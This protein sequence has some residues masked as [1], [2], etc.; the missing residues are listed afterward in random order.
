MMD[1]VAEKFMRLGIENA[2]GQ[3]V[4]QKETVLDLRG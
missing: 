2:P 3:E 1:N 4:L